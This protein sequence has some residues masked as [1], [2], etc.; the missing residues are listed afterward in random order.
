MKVQ[1]SNKTHLWFIVTFFV[2]AGA[3]DANVTSKSAQL[4]QGVVTG[5]VSLNYADNMS[6]CSLDGNNRLLAQAAT[7]HKSSVNT[8]QEIKPELQ[9][10]GIRNHSVSVNG[11]SCYP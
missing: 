11:G 4:F 7:L 2:K 8:K 9:Q 10:S 5:I 3:F 6:I 1:Y